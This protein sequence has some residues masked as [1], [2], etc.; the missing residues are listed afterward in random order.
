[1]Q[2]LLLLVQI[3]QCTL[4]RA[5]NA[6]LELMKALD[7]DQVSMMSRL[8]KTRDTTNHW[9]DRVAQAFAS[10]RRYFVQVTTESSSDVSHR[11]ILVEPEQLVNRFKP[12][13]S[14]GPIL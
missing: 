14:Y 12:M 2:F 3:L 7:R 5:D 13:T 4:V 11:V 6:R 8:I 9:M 1:M 10:S